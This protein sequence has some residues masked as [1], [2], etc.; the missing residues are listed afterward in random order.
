MKKLLIL[1]LAVFAFAACAKEAPVQPAV[2]N[3]TPAAVSFPALDGGEPY[4]FNETN[5]ERPVIF[6]S[7]AGFCGF[8]KKM[9]PYIDELAGKYKGKNVDIIIAFVD[10]EPTELKNLD[11]VKAIKNV[12]VYYNSGRFSQ[13]Q[14]V[15]GFPT[16]FLFDH[17]TGQNQKW[18]GFNPN[19][20]DEMSAAIDKLLQ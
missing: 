13:A 20:V 11:A 17:K 1:T 12:K 9:V 14:G 18:V 10:P 2:Q 7:M 5:L 6:A 15:T 3:P 16:M 4:V 19:A 8:C